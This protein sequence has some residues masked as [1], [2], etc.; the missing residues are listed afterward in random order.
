MKTFLSEIRFG[1]TRIEG[2][3]LHAKSW[4]EAEEQAK[5]IG[6][7]VVGLL[8]EEHVYYPE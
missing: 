6:V 8:Q 1:D 7:E 3:R 5:Q 2:T 4:E